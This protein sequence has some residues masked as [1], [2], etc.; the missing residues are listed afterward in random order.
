MIFYIIYPLGISYFN[1]NKIIYRILITMLLL[2]FSLRVNVGTDYKTY[3]NFYKYPE[4][5]AKANVEKGYLILNL[6]CKK[7][8]LNFVVLQFINL[9]IILF[10]FFQRI[11]QSSRIK[12]LSY[13]IFF[14]GGTFAAS[15][16][17]TRQM[18][19]ASIFFYSIKY[20]TSKKIKKY[21]FLIIL[22]SFFHKSSLLLIPFYYIFKI[23]QKLLYILLCLSFFSE[24]IIFK[25]FYYIIKIFLPKYAKY[26]TNHISRQIIS[27]ERVI[28]FFIPIIIVIVLNEI[29]LGK[30][31]QDLKVYYNLIL[32]SQIFR[33]LAVILPSVLRL[34]YYFT[35][36]EILFFPNFIFALK[37]QKVEYSN[38]LLFFIVIFYLFLYYYLLKTNGHDILPYRSIL[39]FY[40]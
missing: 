27:Y 19:A 6:L 30:Q 28:L 5:M 4:L 12:W 23:K 33:V 29:Y 14:F 13:L 15:L 35:I 26:F 22:S 9:S 21:L 40:D 39:S 8:N 7:F 34:N 20:I 18:I 17:M 24:I 16:N 31:K 25:Y 10:C 37:K 36:F 1:K 32:I 3:L 11:K 2:T 38:I